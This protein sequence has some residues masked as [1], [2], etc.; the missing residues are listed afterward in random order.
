[1][2]YY[3]DNNDLS[4]ERMQQLASRYYSFPVGESAGP[5]QDGLKVMAR[6][7]LEIWALANRRARAALALPAQLAT[8]KSPYALL[9]AYGDFWRGGFAECADT[10]KRISELVSPRSV[11]P[12]ST[13]DK[14]EEPKRAAKTKRNSRSSLNGARGDRVEELRTAT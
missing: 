9:A 10:T 11:K 13:E 3:L 2:N 12:E 7:Q 1:M 14:K 6:C 4:Y 8:C 5:A